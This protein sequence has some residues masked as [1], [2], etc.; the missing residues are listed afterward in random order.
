MYFGF[1]FNDDWTG[2]DKSWFRFAQAVAT[3]IVW[4]VFEIK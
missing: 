2:E 1:K 4:K 3:L